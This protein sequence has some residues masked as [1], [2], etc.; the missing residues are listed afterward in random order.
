MTCKTLILRLL[1]RPSFNVIVEI[2]FLFVQPRLPTPR[3]LQ[4]CN[5]STH[6]SGGHVSGNG[7]Q[8]DRREKSYALG[9]QDVQRDPGH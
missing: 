1:Q 8:V 7:G 3:S 9:T 4:S 5:A 2:G 6:G